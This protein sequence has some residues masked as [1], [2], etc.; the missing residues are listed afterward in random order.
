MHLLLTTLA[1]TSTTTAKKSSSSSST[2]TF[3][4]IIVLFFGVYMLFIRPRSQRMRQQQSAA[5]ALSIGDQVVSAGGI[6][7]TVVALDTD[8]AEVEVAPGVVLTFLRRSI[9]A[10]PDAPPRAPSPP[11]DDGWSVPRD[12]LDA[13][14]AA[15]KPVDNGP[16]ARQDEGVE[17]GD[18]DQSAEPPDQHA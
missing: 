4:I 8:V 16:Q 1:V 11:A 2:L 15:P 6:Q 7:G 12:H 3:L 14:P 13:P 18:Y 9:N 10:R 17:T 5:R